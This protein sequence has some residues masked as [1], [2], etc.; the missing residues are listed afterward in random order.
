MTR[1]QKKNKLVTTAGA[2]AFD[3]QHGSKAFFG[4]QGV[5]IYANGEAGDIVGALLERAGILPPVAHDITDPKEAVAIA[6]GI[7]AAD[8]PVKLQSTINM[9]AITADDTKRSYARR[10]PK[11]VKL[12]GQ[13]V[14]ELYEAKFTVA[15][16]VRTTTKPARFVL[17]GRSL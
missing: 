2:L 4:N 14:T 13:F 11:I 16:A 9:L 15:P 8:L 3:L 1:E 10:L 12:L 6:L 7:T 5:S 17:Q